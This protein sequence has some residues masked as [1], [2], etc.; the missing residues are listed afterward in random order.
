M[1]ATSS[2]QSA[3]T[4]GQTMEPVNIDELDTFELTSSTTDDG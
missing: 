1:S 2:N 3:S 4:A